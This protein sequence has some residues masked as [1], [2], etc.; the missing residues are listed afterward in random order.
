MALVDSSLASGLT[1]VLGPPNSGKL[2]H[3]L[4][5]WEERQSLQ[6]LI[7][8]PT[9][10]DARALSV[11]MA[12]RR[13]AL[14]GQSP[15]VTFDGL[16]RALLGRS[17]DYAG[18]FERSLLVA[19]VLRE[20]PPKAQ[21]F[22]ARFPG[23]TT[24]VAGLLEQ[25]GD[26][27]RSS[28]EIAG[29]LDH[30]SATDP[31]SAVLAA[32]ISALLVRYRVLRDGLGLTDRSD[33]VRQA[34]GAVAGWAHPLALYGFTSFTLAQRGLVEALA[35]VTEMLL[36][37]DY[38]R[39]RRHGLTTVSEFAYWEGLACDVKETSPEGLAYH[40]QAIAHLERHFSDESP[41]A[42][43]HPP[44]WSDGRGVDFLLASGTRNEAELAAF[45]AATLIRSGLAPGDIAVVVRSVRPW[46]RLLAD[47]FASC[48][49]PCQVDEPGEF[50]DSAF[51]Y[52]L[53]A[54]L[55]GSARDDPKSALAYLRS[56]F[57]PADAE[58][59]AD[60]ELDYLRGVVR[61]V[62][63]LVRCVDKVAPG[64]LSGAARCVQRRAEG[65][66]IDLEAT[67]S[68][69]RDLLANS[70][71]CA[72]E[73]DRAADARAFRALEGALSALA[74]HRDSGALPAGV[75][76][77]DVLLP[78]LSRMS[79]PRASTGSMH[80]VQVL[81]AHRARARRFRAVMILGLVEGEFPA[82]AERP[83]L[84]TPGQRARL[85]AIGGGLFPPEGDQEEALFVRAVSRAWDVVLLSAR[86]ADDGGGYAAPSHYWRRCKQLLGVADAAHQHRTLADQV[87]ERAAAP[88]RRQYLRACAAG[89]VEPHAACGGSAALPPRWGRRGGLASLSSPEALQ[90]LAAQHCFSPSAL[91]SYLRC[92]F[93]WFIDRVVGADDM[94]T[95][96]DDRIVGT[97]LHGVMRDTF[98]TLKAEGRLPLGRDDLGSAVRTARA[99]AEM[100]ANSDLCPGTPA[101]RR[102]IEWRLKRMAED[103]LTLEAEAPGLL[104]M[105]DAELE[106]GG[107]GGVDLGGL[108][109]KGRIDRVDRG[110]RGELFIVD[111][112]SGGA[113][114]KRDLGGAKGLQLPLY[115][116]ALAAARPDDEVVGG[117][118]ASAKDK[119]WAGVVRSGCEDLL[120]GG[121]ATCRISDDDA[122]DELLRGAL[123]RAKQ[124]AEG[125]RAGAVAPVP[126]RECDE[127]CDLRP[128]CRAYKGKR[129]R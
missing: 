22:S 43:E 113:P 81:S 70:L 54:A 111:Y 49:I 97:L 15:A 9:V 58:Q 79:I 107:E 1:L 10:P 21:G 76:R 110:P 73:G 80:A 106:I 100:V 71:A 37:I 31:A 50:G 34:A 2:G 29:I 27:G 11:E 127:W 102:L 19:H 42:C 95:V 20:N 8:V 48:G 17:P 12:Q 128:V 25:L 5:W 30:W 64:A 125:M 116:L 75:L 13:G 67:R 98:E 3:V 85:D 45:R 122:L 118:Y 57:S 59:T 103:L 38:E 60:I 109:I 119:A 51:G 91:E 99:F 44:A 40:S 105:S 66:F 18:D 41:P 55:R 72:A 123:A 52:A 69:A 83:A 65:A 117:A 104:V 89:H 23:T 78:A 14:V 56:P 108:S 32:D 124:A 96:A 101:E 112:K 63:G 36:V 39:K 84:L 68:L 92:P 126:E 35:G 74:T 33:A 94:E 61:G 129:A 86:D 4:R 114:E 7:V 62:A 121:R 6:P 53:L 87:F 77:D 24:V 115:M 93:V 88:S 16:V 82:R 120:G 26:S 90:E 47:V 46:G 28:D